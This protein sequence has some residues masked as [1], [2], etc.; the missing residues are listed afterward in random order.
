MENE[1]KLSVIAGT[2]TTSVI[3]SSTAN[4]TDV[5]ITAGSGLSISEVGNVITLTNTAQNTNQTLSLTGQNLT[6][7]PNG[8]TVILP[9]IGVTAG[10]G[11]TTSVTSG[12]ATI[13]LASGYG[14]TQNPYA[15]KNANLFLASPN[16][17]AGVPTFRS[18]VAADIP[19]LNQNTTGTASNVTGTVAVAN[20]GTGA[21]SLTGVLIGNGTS[22]VTGLTATAGSQLLRRNATND[23]FEFW[24]P[25]YVTGNIYTTNGTISGTRT[26]TVS[27]GI[28]NFQNNAGSSGTSG[29][30][31][32]SNLGDTYGLRINNSGLKSAIYATSTSANVLELNT[33]TTTPNTTKLITA[34]N[35]TTPVLDLLAN[36]ELTLGGY[37]TG[38]NTGTLAYVLG[39][40]STGKVIETTTSVH[41][42]VTLVTANGLSLSGQ[43]LSLSLASTSATGALSSTDWNTFNNKQSTISLTTNNNSGAA[44]FS[45][46]TLNIPNYT[47]AG[48]GGLSN[49]TSS[50]QNGYFG[51]IFLYDDAT[52]SHYLQ[53]TNS[54]NL[55]AQRVL[56]VNVNDAD[57]TISLSGNLTVSGNATISGTN[58]G[59][60]TITLTGDVTGSGTGSFATT[61]ANTT[62]VPNDY[63][64]ATITVDSKGRITSASSNT[65]P[66]VNNGTL[67]LNV[68]GTGLSGS[69]T[70]TANQ[71]TNATFTVTSNAT[72][73]NTASTI[74][75]RDA[76]GNFTAGTITGALSGNATTASTL[77][78]A[79]TIQTNLASTSAASF[80]GSAD[81]TPGI[82]GTLPIGNGGTGGTTAATAIQNLLPSYTSNNSKVLALNSTATALEWITPTGG[83]GGIGGTG[84]AS[85]VAFFTDA[86]TLS[87]NTN[88][89][90]DNTNGRLGIGTTT[91]LSRLT[92]YGVNDFNQLTDS[93][94][95]NATLSLIS[96]DGNYGSGGA[97]TFGTEYSRLNNTLGFA[98]IKGLL[99]DNQNNTRG[100]LAFYTRNLTTDTLFTERLRITATGNVG[101]G[102]TA[103]N[104]IL[105]LVRIGNDPVY[106]SYNNGTVNTVTGTSGG[107]VN[108]VSL[109][110]NT[111]NHPIAF[112]A[113]NTEKMRISANG[114][115]GIGTS[116]PSSILSLNGDAAQTFGMERHTTANTA[117]NAFT[118]Q[119]GGATS[120]ATDKIGGALFLS[121]GTS[122]GNQRSVI[123]FST[124][125]PGVSGTA[126]N[127]PV[128]RVRINNT[129]MGVGT[130]NPQNRLDVEGGAAIGA[131]YSGTNTAPTNGLIVEGSVGIGTNN[132]IAKLNLV[133]G[134]A[135]LARFIGN[136]SN[137]Y[138]ELSDNNGTN[139]VSYG[140]INGG[141]SYTYTQGYHAVYTGGAERF[142]F[143]S[144]GLLGIG[145]NNPT[146]ILSLNG[147]AAR[148]IWMERHTTANTA[149]NNL[150]IQA[151][152]A[153]STATNQNGGNLILESGT[154]TGTG[155]SSIIFET[156][157]AGVVPTA[158]NTPTEK[159]R[160][161][162]LGNVG[163]G[164]TAPTAFG[165]GVTLQV[166][167][168]TSK[169]GILL[170]TNGTINYR[171]QVTGSLAYT[172]TTSNHGYVIQTY[173]TNRVVVQS[174]GKVGV[175]RDA[176]ATALS[177]DGAIST[178]VPVAIST[179]NY[180]IPETG[181]WFYITSAAVNNINFPNAATYPGRII[182][183]KTIVGVPTGNVNVTVSGTN[184]TIWKLSGHENSQV[185]FNAGTLGA[186]AWKKL[187]SDGTRW[188]TVEGSG[189]GD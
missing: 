176:P 43:Q 29:V 41:D 75:A 105:S 109:F 145:T 66:T 156:S 138:I 79:R 57:R 39:V 100:E 47:L 154:A 3:R 49:S 40:T 8:N 168:T 65:I 27:G 174:D 18:I 121:S 85:K 42:A 115:V 74:V 20:G 88:F 36:G 56:S 15:S 64:A 59:D 97:I 13:S 136:N 72:S 142:R 26:V 78:T 5:T 165:N 71:S 161:D 157:T 11:I 150:T 164:T 187:V 70:F 93:A 110:G 128:E 120:G 45:S 90:W 37:G 147:N 141:N 133:S 104:D 82:T 9:L 125:T 91:P 17:T 54:A 175:S 158:D 84:V 144:S 153:T 106:I 92:L 131:T 1:G 119:A 35:G 86:S 67:T 166:G 103:P 94:P 80:N 155:S 32:I 38:T 62:V 132:P 129:G 182:S 114:N 101:I 95:R 143:T 48:L 163:I 162:G 169:Q 152:G 19:T 139:T 6:I 10:T 102:T 167:S 108:A 23:G 170:L 151:G 46:N 50:T 123:V 113:N 181:M 148:T 44:T 22:A 77:Q 137:N 87:T 140:S 16:G 160:I 117:G 55:T 171:S 135:R 99:I 76:S 179:N 96:S 173:N 53:I 61:L 33:T 4:S 7:E 177:V 14:D 122:T 73:A 24:T 98:G 118:I 28:L 130:S 81:I 180:S 116:S 127:A 112:Y 31:N 184:T 63:T 189:L 183:I 60:Q 126:D 186:G 25:T 58:T 185:L 21:T 107:G 188:I 146:N 172:G 178:S 68:S 52:P 34:T 159:M 69:Q 83:T 134:E 51:D 89:H 30:V 149:G 2:E 111:T 124:P 12:N